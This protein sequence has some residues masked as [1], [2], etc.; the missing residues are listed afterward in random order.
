MIGKTC[1]ITGA[2]SGI[3]KALSI[4]LSEHGAHLVLACRDK[5]RGENAIYEIKEKTKN[6]NIDLLLVDLSSPKSI[7]NCAFE[8]KKRYDRLDVL[9]NNAGTL[10]FNK[11]YNEYGIETTFATNYLGPFLLTNL[12]LDLLIASAPSR[13]I[14]VVSEGTT[15]GKIDLRFLKDKKKYDPVLAYSQSKQAEIFFTYELAERLKNT[16]VTSN[17]FYPGLVKTN[18]GYVE[19]GFRK[20]TYNLLTSLLKFVFLPIEE[21]V[22]IGMYLAVSKKTESLSGKFLKRQKDKIIIISSYNKN[23]S[24]KLWEI[25]EKLSGYNKIT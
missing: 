15:K 2:N 11:T 16:H 20:F 13:I 4:A 10:L 1:L 25:S 18:L 12:L 5:T 23:I 19:K 17:C 6:P 8:Y 9:I 24:K 3:G 21:S 14:N 7:R 22:K